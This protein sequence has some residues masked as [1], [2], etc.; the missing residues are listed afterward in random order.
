MKRVVLFLVI[1]AT[2]AGP[3]TSRARIINVPTDSSSIQAGINGAVDGDTVLVARGHYYERINFLGKAIVVAS[4]F[5]FDHD[6]VTVDSTTIDA[7]TLVLGASDTGSV[8]V[9]GSYEN[10]SSILEG[11]TLQNGSGTRGSGG[12]ICCYYAGPTIRNN[13][14]RFNEADGGGAIDCFHRSHPRITGNRVSENRADFGGAIRCDDFSCPV[15]ESNVIC[16]NFSKAYGGGIVCDDN[17]SPSITRNLIANNWTGLG[18]IRGR[19]L[20]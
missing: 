14:L 20:L 2:F 17:S 8:V 16:G 19:Y 7:D 13:R 3:N 4:N 12:G 6:T 15:I 10:S 1:L 5:T 11:F 18:G 9:F